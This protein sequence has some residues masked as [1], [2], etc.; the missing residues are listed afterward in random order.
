MDVYVRTFLYHIPIL[1]DH[2]ALMPMHGHSC[3]FLLPLF[4][5]YTAILVSSLACATIDV[6]TT[7]RCLRAQLTG[8]GHAII[9]NRILLGVDGRGCGSARDQGA[10]AIAAED[11][12]CTQQD[13]S[14]Q[15][16]M[17]RVS[18]ACR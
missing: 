6:L 7:H 12:S 17:R 8:S 13:G 11:W 18:C 3:T 9:R 15:Q 10:H 2:A 4:N 5:L 16:A 14:T 1:I